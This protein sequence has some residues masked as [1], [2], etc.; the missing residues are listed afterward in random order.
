[1]NRQFAHQNNQI[2]REKIRKTTYINSVKITV[3]I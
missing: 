2:E 3:C 1:M